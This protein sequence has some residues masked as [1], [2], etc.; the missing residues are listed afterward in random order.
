[1]LQQSRNGI[2][3]QQRREKMIVAV[4]A[5]IALIL[6]AL[7]TLR[8]SCLEKMMATLCN[9]ITEGMKEAKEEYKREKYG[10]TNR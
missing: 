8:V 9:T 5:A 1:M 10:K 3:G 2:I 7:N 4:I 6:S